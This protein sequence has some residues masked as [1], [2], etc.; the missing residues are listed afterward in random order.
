MKQ[1][2]V[3]YLIQNNEEV[4]DMPINELLAWTTQRKVRRAKYRARSVMPNTSEE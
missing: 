1:Q 2:R 3:A 4:S